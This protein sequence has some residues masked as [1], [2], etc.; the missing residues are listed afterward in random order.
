MGVHIGLPHRSLQINP[1]IVTP[2]KQ[3]CL[4]KAD[5]DTCFLYQRTSVSA[6][7]HQ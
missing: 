6:D 2:P 1:P 5:V 7:G 3:M 4:T